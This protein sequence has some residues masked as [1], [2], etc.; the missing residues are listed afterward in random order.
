MARISLVVLFVVG[1]L[2]LWAFVYSS[3]DVPSAVATRSLVAPSRTATTAPASAVVSETTS[4]EALAA[5]ESDSN[6]AL[7]P[8]VDFGELQ[9]PRNVND[10]ASAAV[11]S[12]STTTTTKA[13]A[14][15]SRDPVRI[16]KPACAASLGAPVSQ[17]GPL[18]GTSASIPSGLPAVV[19]KVSNNNSKSRAA[20]TGL[21]R[22]DVVFEERI[23]A[24]ATRF[25]AVFH[26]DL[27]SVV[28]PVRSGRTTDINLLRNLGTPVLGYSGSN[29]GVAGQIADAAAKGWF[30]PVI[31]TDR[32]PFARD[33]RY[34]A[35]DNLF[36]DP[37]SLGACG[38]GGTP[39]PIFSYG[40]ASSTS[41]QPASFV[42]LQARSP[43]RFD[44]DAGSGTWRRSQDGYAH[45]TRTGE[46]L[47]PENVIVMFVR[48]VPSAIDASSV[49]A[50]STGT[51]E[52]WLMRDGTITRGA[53]ARANAT[54]SYRIEDADGKLARLKPGQTWVVL[55]PAGTA[56]WG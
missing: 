14:A 20:L 21:D 30:V 50:I 22:A 13:P 39:S 26:S 53:W 36:V 15:P 33:N 27:P 43:Y 51:G 8:P 25:A 37:T 12:S 40:A 38:K 49:D 44:W 42:S 54:T 55:A 35:P 3:S 1:L 10:V 19:V 52:A 4:P 29:S 32:S 7:V 56:S 2:G 41:A 16:P 17:T 31:N 24:K 9:I 23:E 46:R 6:R 28:G 18:S 34:S 48:Y 5:V 47:A 45:S 11:A